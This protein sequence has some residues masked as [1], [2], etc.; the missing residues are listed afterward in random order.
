AGSMVTSAE[1]LVT[2]T[3]TSRQTIRSIFSFLESTKAITIKATKRWT[4]LT[5]IN[6]HTYQAI[7]KPEQ[8]TEE[9]T[10]QPWLGLET[11]SE[12]TN[13]VTRSV[14]TIEEKRSN[15]TTLSKSG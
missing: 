15:S 13:G 2:Q 3:R 6:W 1:K 12:V 14:T 11:A 8:P 9:P 7:V 4:M 5:V 10:E